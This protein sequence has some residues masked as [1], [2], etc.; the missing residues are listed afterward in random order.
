MQR[1]IDN[2]GVSKA[3]LDELIEKGELRAKHPEVAEQLDFYKQAQLEAI[4][5]SEKYGEREPPLYAESL[6]GSRARGVHRIGARAVRSDLEGAHGT[7]NPQTGEVLTEDLYVVIEARGGGSE[8]GFKVIAQVLRSH[9]GPNEERPGLESGEA[10]RSRGRQGS[11][12]ARAQETG[13]LAR[14]RGTREGGNGQLEYAKVKT[15]VFERLAR[16]APD[17]PQIQKFLWQ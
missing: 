5:T 15:P 7:L 6:Q 14:A 13:A 10:V 17:Y 1:I 4:R 12:E 3:E 16:D 9:P 11:S 8:L 2:K